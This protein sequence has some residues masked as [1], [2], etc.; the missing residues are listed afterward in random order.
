MEQL[1]SSLEYL[2]RRLQLFRG[3]SPEALE[4]DAIPAIA[5][6]KTPSN[7]PAQEKL[8]ESTEQLVL[9]VSKAANGGHQFKGK[10]GFVSCFGMHERGHTFFFHWGQTT[11]DLLFS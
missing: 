7:V 10:H 4:E 5:R 8:F 1:S 11:S 9:R 3:P 2:L 6:L